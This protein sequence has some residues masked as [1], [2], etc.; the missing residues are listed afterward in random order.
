MQGWFVGGSHDEQ[1]SDAPVEHI[2][3]K[4]LEE[5]NASLDATVGQ[6][7]SEIVKLQS[8]HKEKLYSLQKELEAMRGENEALRLKNATLEELSS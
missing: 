8:S 7:R 3:I 4:K 1:D 2:R 6:L 5:R